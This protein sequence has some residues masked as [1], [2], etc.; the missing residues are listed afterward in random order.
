MGI[1]EQN[2]KK[3]ANVLE[4]DTQNKLNLK[5][6]STLADQAYMKIA[7]DF[8]LLSTVDNIQNQRS[9]PF[10]TPKSSAGPKPT[11]EGLKTSKPETEK[12]EVM[13][14]VAGSYNQ[15]IVMTA[16]ENQQGNWSGH[17]TQYGYSG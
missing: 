10:D 13:K 5:V 7:N 16:G 15:A 4:V 2:L 9:N 17:G 8:K 1:P 12:K 6:G 14:P 11:L 3:H